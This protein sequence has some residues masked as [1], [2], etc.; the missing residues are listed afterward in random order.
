ML[1]AARLFRLRIMPARSPELLPH[2]ED[3]LILGSLIS[4]S[5]IFG[6]PVNAV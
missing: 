2:A 1:L 6:K 3:E 4:L 5:G